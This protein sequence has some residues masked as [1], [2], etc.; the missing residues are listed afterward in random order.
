ADWQHGLCSCFDNCLVCI[1]TYIAPC[2]TAGKNAEAVGESCLMCGLV[3]FVPLL[4]IFCQAQIRSKIRE[5]KNIEGGMIGDLLVHCC[6]PCCA[7]SQEAQEVNALG[8]QSID[9]Q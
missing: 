1:I 7:L 3:T 4:N 2:Y 6:C 8:G 5:Q 9:R